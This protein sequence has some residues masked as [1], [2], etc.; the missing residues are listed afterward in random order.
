MW[1]IPQQGSVHCKH[2]T[3]ESATGNSPNRAIHFQELLTLAL[4]VSETKS[5]NKKHWLHIQSCQKCVKQE[6]HAIME[7]WWG[8]GESSPEEQPCVRTTSPQFVAKRAVCM[9]TWLWPHILKQA[10]SNPSS[11]EQEIWPSL[12]NTVLTNYPAHSCSITKLSCAWNIDFRQKRTWK[13]GAPFFLS[14]AVI[15]RLI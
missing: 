2:L 14:I 7:V 3:R 11:T 15:C 5:L 13:K 4:S 12:K 10:V 9:Q 8:K 6:R 1:N